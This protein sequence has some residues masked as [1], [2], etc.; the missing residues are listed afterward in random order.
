MN[1]I[2]RYTV[3]FLLAIICWM[4]SYSQQLP[5]YSQFMLNDFALN[6]AIAGKNADFWE[7]KSN[8]RYQWVGI[9]DAPRT[10]VL[11][12]NGPVSNG[13]MGLGGT[14][15]TDIVGPTRRIGL[16]FSYSYHLKINEI[17]KLN[18]GVSAG[19]LQYSVDG[20][21]LILQDYSDLVLTNQYKSALLP[22]FGTGAYFYSKKLFLSFSVP[23][24]FNAQ[25]KFKD[26]EHSDLSRIRPHFYLFGGYRFNLQND[27]ELEPSLMVKWRE[28]TPV[29]MDVGARIIY[30][31]M[32]WIGSYFRTKDAVSAI[33]GYLHKDQLWVAYSYDF[34]TTNLRN[35]STGTHEIMLGLKFIS[36]KQNPR[37]ISQ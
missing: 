14:L 31:N 32:L 29:K 28:P 36:P 17:Y 20:H 7:L 23:Q 4:S 27:F 34:T 11:S 37:E 5:Q 26:T 2:S 15:F 30:R 9:T 6:P 12:L 35:Y 16:N 25:V 22:D 1:V 33:L 24:L 13:K 3:S 18:L 8:N 19:L 10:Y 21:K